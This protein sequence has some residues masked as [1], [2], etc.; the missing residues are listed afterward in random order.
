M[1]LFITYSCIVYIYNINT[2]AY[3]YINIISICTHYKWIL[4]RVYNI[5]IIRFYTE[6]I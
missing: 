6:C 4:I 3:L 5:V 2:T 1:I